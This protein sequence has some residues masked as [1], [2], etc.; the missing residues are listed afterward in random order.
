LALPL[1]SAR[2]KFGEDNTSVGALIADDGTL[3]VFVLNDTAM[4]RV[5]TGFEIIAEVIKSR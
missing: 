4:Q 1:F 5:E 3:E 2:L